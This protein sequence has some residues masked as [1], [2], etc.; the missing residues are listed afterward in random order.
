MDGES[1]DVIR[2]TDK[3]AA[4]VNYFQKLQVSLS[5]NLPRDLQESDGQPPGQVQVQKR[6]LE[7]YWAF[8]M[9]LLSPES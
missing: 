9:G 4:D 6:A 7:H 8:V 5:Q 1:G 3:F 2:F